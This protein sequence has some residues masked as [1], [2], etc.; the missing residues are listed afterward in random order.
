[1]DIS[2]K[3]LEIFTSVVVAGSITN[4]SRRIQLSQPS[5]SQQ[6]AKLEERL[7]TQLIRRSRTGPI[8]LTAAGEYWFKSSTDLLRRYHSIL[9]DHKVRFSEQSVT[10]R[11]GM[12]PT[13][14]GRFAGAVAR[15]ML[16]EDPQARFEQV[17]ALNSM[18]LVE[19]LR[20]HQ[21]NCALVNS[22]AIEEDRSSYS[23]TPVFTD[24]LA[25]VV[26]RQVPIKLIR[27]ALR[28]D[29]SAIEQAPA[30]GRYVGVGPGAPMQAAT[31]DWYRNY[32]PE[33]TATFGALTYPG[34]ID[35]V[36]EGVATAHCPVSLLP[37]LPES[38]ARQLRW[39]AIEALTRDIVLVM[40]KHLLTLPAY[41]RIY[42]RMQE[43]AHSQYAG[44][45]LRSGVVPVETL[46]E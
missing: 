17:W 23:V 43:F 22:I 35:L 26:P 46:M 33:A 9:E 28:G 25:W 2:L 18:E 6:L 7:G 20:V 8:E 1:M 4:A 10:I 41:S 24:Q 31:D 13:L 30:L 34:A 12:T 3:Q 15:I 32:L 44:E 19:R 21:L 45:M 37:N 40:P 29:A 42:A 11:M 16:Q 39:Y 5:I 38:V 27:K 14:R 36:A